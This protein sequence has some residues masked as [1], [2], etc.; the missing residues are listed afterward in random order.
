MVSRARDRER[1]RLRA[2]VH[3]APAAHGRDACL[4]LL[5]AP[6]RRRE[7]RLPD[8]H[9]PPR[10]RIRQAGPQ[11]V[12]SGR[13][14]PGCG[15]ADRAARG[16]GCHHRASRSRAGARTSQFSTTRSRTRS[17]NSPSARAGLSTEP[18]LAAAPW[19]PWRPVIPLVVAGSPPCARARLSCCLVSSSS[20]PSV[21][22]RPARRTRRRSARSR[23]LR[24]RVSGSRDSSSAPRITTRASRWCPS[25]RGTRR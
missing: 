12:R 22:G 11:D 9:A 18:A 25:S 1:V 19:V 13:G 4:V 7:M 6:H 24:W 15:A 16:G 21:R 17:P 3:A 10:G 23:F 20:L 14:S 2:P 8:L 5:C